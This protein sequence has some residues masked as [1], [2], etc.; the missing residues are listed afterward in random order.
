MNSLMIHALSPFARS[1]R[2]AACGLALLAA[3][4]AMAPAAAFAAAQISGSPQAVNVQVQNSSVQEVLAALEGQFKL[5]VRSSANLDKQV[6]GTYQGSLQRVVARLLEG[7]SF[8]LTTNQNG[9]EVTILGAPNGAGGTVASGTGTASVSATIVGTP[10]APANTPVQNAVTAPVPHPTP[11]PA[12]SSPNMRAANAQPGAPVAVP[13]NGPTPPF[14]VAEGT[15]PMPT[16]IPAGSSVTG[17]VPG[18][19]TS[20]MPE[21]KPSTAQMPTVT[22]IQNSAAN[23]AMLP[24]PTAST[25]FPMGGMNT[26]AAAVMTT[27]ASTPNAPGAPTPGASSPGAPTAK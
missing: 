22:P 21:P 8:V 2:R 23:G 24:M 7:Y 16:P 20:T 10:A 19:A 25:P 1:P 17:P 12:V 15:G 5:Q 26:P 13:A 3:G 11:S 27:P 4:L 9:I 6:T 18:P 14:R